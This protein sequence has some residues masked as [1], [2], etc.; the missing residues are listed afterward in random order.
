MKKITAS[1]YRQLQEELHYLVKKQVI[2]KE[3]QEQALEQYEVKEGLS[4]LSI[5]LAIGAILI[6][7][8]VLIAVSTNWSQFSLLLKFSIL[9]ISTLASY[10]V[11]FALQH[12]FEKTAR[13]FYYIAAF[14]TG[15]SLYFIASLYMNHIETGTIALMWAITLIPLVLFLVDLPITLLFAASL[16][17]ASAG[18]ATIF[19]FGILLILPLIA[20][21]MWVNEVKLKESKLGFFSV[22]LVLV[23]WI[24]ALMSSIDVPG[25]VPISLIFIL[26]IA[27]F[28]NHFEKYFNLSRWLGTIIISITSLSLMGRF[29]WQ[30]VSENSASIYSTSFTIA[31]AIF[32]FALLKYAPLQSIVFIGILI[33][34]LYFDYTFDLI[35]QSLFFVI[36]GLLMIGFGYWFERTRRN[37]GQ[38]HA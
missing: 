24:A 5:I 30:A 18:Y 10:V 8:G 14:I 12:H 7:L 26:G 29:T 28:F 19:S 22:V 15:A 4:T 20:F 34:R 32:A 23:V 17:W 36:A 38:S 31:F 11:A 35:P 37:E 33:A 25:I 21:L 3:Q 27:L 13:A 2:S 16:L 1:Y 9:F 6:G